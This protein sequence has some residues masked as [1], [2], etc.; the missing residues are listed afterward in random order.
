MGS[1]RDIIMRTI[2][3]IAAF[4]LMGGTPALASDIADARAHDHHVGVV[5]SGAPSMADHAHH[6]HHGKGDQ[7]PS[8]H[9]EVDRSVEPEAHCPVSLAPVHCEVCLDRNAIQA[10]ALR[11]REHAMALRDLRLS[12]PDPVSLHASGREGDHLI[13]AWPP[14]TQRVRALSSRP[15]ALAHRFRI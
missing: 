7:S 12:S 3:V 5:A 2:L 9:H 13:A 15:L 8:G 6:H 4:L 14:D 10:S 11:Q 1:T